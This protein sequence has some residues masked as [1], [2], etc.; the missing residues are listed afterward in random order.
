MKNKED[1]L[2]NSNYDDIQEYD[3]DLPKWWV[4]LFYVTIAF[5]VVYSIYY[6]SGS[7]PSSEKRL[8]D[9]LASIKAL[10]P[11]KPAHDTSAEQLLALVKSPES[12]NAGKVV[13]QK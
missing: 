8:Q 7:A 3:N 12:I 9:Q 6:F 11:A 4:W 1:Q 13:F 5:A 10:A 2:L